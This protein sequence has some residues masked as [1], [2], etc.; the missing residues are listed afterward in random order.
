VVICALAGLALGTPVNWLADRL[1]RNHPEVE[2]S[3]SCPHWRKPAD[4]V[5]L[6]G[7][8]LRRGRCPNCGRALGW[9]RPVVDITSAA[10]LGLSYGYYGLHPQ[11]ALTAFWGLA[12][13]LIAVIDFEHTLILNKVTYPLI[14]LALV[15]SVLFP[16]EIPRLILPWPAQ[17]SGLIG[18]AAGFI[19]LFLIAFVSRGG[20]GWGDVKAAAL[21]GMV[22]GFP[23]VLVALFLGVVLGGIVAA[24][25]LLTRMRKRKDGIP[26]GPFLSVG[27]LAALFAG[28]PLLAWYLRLG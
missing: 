19:L 26:F 7:Y 23:L 12:F 2:F 24:F 6:L 4:W 10:I 18:A 16:M 20:M 5:P 27:T 15:L 13:L 25:L 8:F 14:A 9:R 3:V 1:P 11:F 28:A 22:T 17:L 21:I